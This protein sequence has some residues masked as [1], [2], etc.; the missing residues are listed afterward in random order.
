[1]LSI[2]PA[3]FFKEE[4]HYSVIFPDFNYLSTC[5][6][7]LQDAMEMAVDCLAGAL[8]S[9]KL[10]NEDIPIPSKLEEI[11]PTQ[12]A[13]ELEFEFKQSFVTLVSVDVEE[14]AKTHFNKAIKKTLTI[15]E[16]YRHDRAFCFRGCFKASAF[17]LQHL[18]SHLRSCSFREN[19]IIPSCLH[20]TDHIDDHLHGLLQ[21]FSVNDE[22][23]HAG[24]NLLQERDVC[25]FFLSYH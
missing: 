8:F 20:L 19:Q 4:N 3:C 24:K 18:I 22:C 23:L 7:S 1:M 10:D 11:D 14:Y 25:Y 16:W 9:A 6:D 2:Y 13:S 5:G 15:P 17:E 21:V 12:I